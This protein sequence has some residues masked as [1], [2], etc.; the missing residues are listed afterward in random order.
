MGIM[1][2]APKYNSIDVTIKT[3]RA[4]IGFQSFASTGMPNSRA[5]IMTMN[6]AIKERE[7]WNCP[8]LTVSDTSRVRLS[9]N[10]KI[11]IPLTKNIAPFDASES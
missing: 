11:E 1:G 4:A 5:A 9:E 2:I 8:T 6:M 10:P 7:K 3:V